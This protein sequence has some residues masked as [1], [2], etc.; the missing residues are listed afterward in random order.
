MKV[1]S[2][3]YELQQSNVTN[4]TLP[5]YPYEVIPGWSTI[6]IIAGGLLVIFALILILMGIL[7]L[8][9]LICSKTRGKVLQDSWELEK[10][11]QHK[12]EKELE[13][14][15][16]LGQSKEHV[17]DTNVPTHVETIIDIPVEEKKQSIEIVPPPKEQSPP[18]PLEVPPE[19]QP[20]PI[21]NIAINI[22]SHENQ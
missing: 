14:K 2:I 4:S 1:D 15:S 21:P 20:N 8:G 9:D 18:P 7:S 11:K 13:K 17:S 3:F 6:I 5:T 19:P 22:E 16:L 10:H 12:M